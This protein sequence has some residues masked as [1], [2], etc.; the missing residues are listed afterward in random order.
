MYIQG[1][2][3]SPVNISMEFIEN[4]G[5]YGGGLFLGSSNGGVNLEGVVFSNNSAIS[6]G[7]AIY[8]GGENYGAIVKNH[9]LTGNFASVH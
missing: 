5:K 8:F 3:L 2:D 7:V 9:F 1:E 4:V 6:K